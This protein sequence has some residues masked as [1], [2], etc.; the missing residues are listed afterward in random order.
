M[1]F[2]GHTNIEPMVPLQ[3]GMKLWAI[4]G[5]LGGRGDGKSQSS[6]LSLVYIF[7]KIGAALLLP[8][9]DS[10]PYSLSY[11]VIGA[12]LFLKKKKSTN[13]YYYLKT[14]E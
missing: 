2:Q 3:V 12:Q 5:E 4:L 9:P 7:R 11:F 6:A 13:Y 10:R 14:K 1:D 8:S